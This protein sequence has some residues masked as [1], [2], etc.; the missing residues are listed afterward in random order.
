M[1]CKDKN[2]PAHGKLAVR[3]NIFTGRIVS[4]KMKN[5]VVV[6]RSHL[7]RVQKYERYERA[8]SRITA[9][10]P[11]CVEAHVGDLVE[12]SECRKISKTKSFVITKVIEG[13]K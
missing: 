11:E 4:D 12:I 8:K 13:K 7:K 9:H 3:G 6:E 1:D 5:S 10:K 2:C